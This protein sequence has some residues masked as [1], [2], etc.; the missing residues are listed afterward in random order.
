[1]P[2]YCSGDE[3]ENILVI[4]VI[5]VKEVFACEWPVDSGVGWNSDN[6]T[7]NKECMYLTEIIHTASKCAASSV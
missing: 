7:E 4:S 6:D 3:R 5:A 1:M 2:L